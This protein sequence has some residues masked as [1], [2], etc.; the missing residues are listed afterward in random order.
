MFA[1]IIH[2]ATIVRMNTKHSEFEINGAKV[3][4]YPMASVQAVMLRVMIRAGSWYE[5]GPKWG[6]FHLLEH[7]TYNATK[8]FPNELAIEFF[9]EKH[10]ISNNAWTGNSNMGYWFEFPANSLD[11][12]FDI[13]N[14]LVFK[15]LIPE[16]QL[17]RESRVVSQEF[18]DWWS[19][20]RTRF[21]KAYDELLY[22]K[23]HIY[24]RDGIGQP[25]FVDSLTQKDLLSLQRQ[26]MKPK[27]MVITIVGKVNKD[28]VKNKLKDILSEQKGGKKAKL[29]IPKIK[30]TNKRYLWHK[31]DF[32]RVQIS[33]IWRTPGRDK[34]SI[35]D[36]M[37]FNLAAYLLGGTAR[38]RLFRKLRLEMG[39]VYKTG[40][41]FTTYPTTGEFEIWSSASPESAQKVHQTMIKVVDDFLKNSIPDE[42]FERSKN[43][44]NMRRLL[45][46]DSV[47]SIASSL[48]SHLFLRK[49]SFVAKRFYSHVQ[50]N[51]K[52]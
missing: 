30:N 1:K 43:Y 34:L 50:K 39:L 21:G 36:K 7:M 13:F 10:G 25:E 22:G 46:Y 45:A 27:N 48:A 24:I 47:S 26:Y 4:V 5:T 37:R 51:Q 42:E 29:N 18:V 31:E 52:R 11:A 32:D 3:A 38:S 8:A 14:E 16:S 20:P 44:L 12:G 41:N 28:K 35:T 6:A 33:T 17:A 40:A 15:P 23:N 49:Q 2:S 19:E 9:K